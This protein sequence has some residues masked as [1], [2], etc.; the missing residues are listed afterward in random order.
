MG[1]ASRG[2]VRKEGFKRVYSTQTE[3]GKKILLKR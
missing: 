1:P 2:A 3:K